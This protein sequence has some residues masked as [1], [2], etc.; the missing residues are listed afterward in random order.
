LEV[1][2]CDLKVTPVFAVKHSIIIPHKGREDNLRLCLDSIQYSARS[3]RIDDYEVLI[4]GDVPHEIVPPWQTHFLACGCYAS[5]H[6]LRFYPNESPPFWK[7]SLL[8]TGIWCATGDVLTFLD[9]DAIV[10]RYFMRG[11]EVLANAPLTL[12][13]YRVRLV[14]SSVTQ[15]NVAALFAEYDTLPKAHEAYGCP[16]DGQ[17]EPHHPVFGNSQFSIRRD[18]LGDLRFDEMYF[19]RGMED[20]DM[21]RRIYGHYGTRY[22]AAIM[23]DAEHAM[24]H[25][26]H[27]HSPGYGMDRWAER[28]AR[29]YRGEKHVWVEC[30]NETEAEQLHRILCRVTACG[31]SIVD[32]AGP[33]R[34]EVLP[35]DV[36]LDLDHPVFDSDSP[37]GGR[38]GDDADLSRNLAQA[39][40]D[41]Q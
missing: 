5:K 10:G 14:P 16:E 4:V 2:I 3:C 9:A 27:P 13:A 31:F 6:K 33:W 37:F 19:G 39:L 32:P 20:L 22:L 8:N 25:I 18:V 40:Q 30:N 7:T 11:A 15:G 21:M 23:T 1:T 29:L 26:K 24:L 12:L 17:A 38:D 35:G 34:S 41:A 28:N 36:V